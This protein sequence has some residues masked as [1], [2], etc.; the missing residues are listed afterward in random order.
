M[1]GRRK[2]ILTS[3]GSLS[4]AILLAEIAFK[5]QLDKAKPEG[6]SKGAEISCHSA[7]R[8]CMTAIRQGFTKGNARGKI[9]NGMALLFKILNRKCSCP[10]S[11]CFARSFPP[12]GSREAAI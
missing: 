9:D 4:F 8:D 3:L 5:R 7:C 2:R 10:S 6:E 11:P 12:R 1:N